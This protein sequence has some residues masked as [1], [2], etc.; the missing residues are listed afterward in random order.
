MIKISVIIPVY[1]EESRLLDNFKKIAKY[2]SEQKYSSEIIFIDDGSTDKTLDIINGLC[3]KNLRFFKNP[4]NMGKGYA[5]RSGVKY[6]QG[7]YILLTDIDNSTPIDN[8]NKLLP[9]AKKYPIVIG[10]RYL[11]KDSI[12]IKQPLLRR[13]ISRAGNLFIRIILGLRFRDTQCGFKLLEAKSAKDIFNKA[14]IN[15]WGF[16]IEL[17]AIAKKYQIPAK[18]VAVSWYDDPRTKLRAGRAAIGT[19]KEVLQIKKNLSTDRYD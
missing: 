12:K 6:A 3:Y 5:I 2:L 7:E 16:D 9:Y 14:T 17:L 18:E 4:Q 1:N 19:F 11:E 10:S 15:R 13:I 8:L